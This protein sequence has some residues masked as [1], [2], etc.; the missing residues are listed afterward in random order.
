MTLFISN[1]FLLGDL[2]KVRKLL[3]RGW[4]QG[5]FA[6]DRSGDST[7]PRDR[8]ATC[9]CLTG[10]VDRA[11]TDDRRSLTE[12]V[13]ANEDLRRALRSTLPPRWAGDLV[14]FNDCRS[15]RLDQVLALVD[16]T[17]AAYS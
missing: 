12:R 7:A 9:W 16:K 15:R 5:V 11:A 13:Q 1:R 17:I 8:N 2:A 4:T 10:A 3:Q 6:R 14:A